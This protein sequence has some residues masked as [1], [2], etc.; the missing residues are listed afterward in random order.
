MTFRSLRETSI[1]TIHNPSRKAT[2]ISVAFNPLGPLYGMNKPPSIATRMPRGGHRIKIE[3][4]TTPTRTMRMIVKAESENNSANS[5][6]NPI[7]QPTTRI[8]NEVG[9]VRTWSIDGILE[10]GRSFCMV[11]PV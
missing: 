2:T 9:F 7:T 5:A 6:L 3:A 8:F 11:F 4:A 1:S 10:M